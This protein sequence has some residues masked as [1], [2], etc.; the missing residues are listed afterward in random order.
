MDTTVSRELGIR[1][2]PLEFH[3][4]VYLNIRY[5]MK[6]IP[7]NHVSLCPLENIWKRSFHGGGG[8]GGGGGVIIPAHE[9]KNG[10]S[11][12]DLDDFS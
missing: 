8:G 1:E 3:V 9:S 11:N 2:V 7:D 4:H 10:N 5:F 12:Q 6:N